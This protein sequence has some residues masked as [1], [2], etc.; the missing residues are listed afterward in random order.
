ML[1]R[2]AR[3]REKTRLGRPIPIRGPL[4]NQAVECFSGPVLGRVLM[5]VADR[6]QQHVGDQIGGQLLEALREPI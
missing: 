2:L 4:W 1:T 5:G 3:T 6:V